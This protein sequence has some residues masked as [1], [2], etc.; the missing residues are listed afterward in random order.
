MVLVNLEQLSTDELRNL[1]E[2]EKIEGFDSLPIVFDS[3]FLLLR[4]DNHRSFE[5]T[6]EILFLFPYLPPILYP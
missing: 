1:S 5:M 2:Q 6:F 4:Q 3:F